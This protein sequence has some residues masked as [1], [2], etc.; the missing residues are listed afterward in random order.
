MLRAREKLLESRSSLAQLSELRRTAFRLNA[1]AW[2]SLLMRADKAVVDKAF[3]TNYDCDYSAMLLAHGGA[4]TSSAAMREVCPPDSRRLWSARA[5]AEAL[6]RAERRDPQAMRATG[7]NVRALI[8]E[9][10]QAVCALVAASAK[11]A[12]RASM[13]A[14]T[15]ANLQRLVSAVCA[16]SHAQTCLPFVLNLY[17]PNSCSQV[18]SAGSTSR[19]SLAA[20]RYKQE[21]P[22][23]TVT[24]TVT[25]ALTLPLILI[26]T[27]ILTLSLTLTLGS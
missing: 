26:P 27:L 4:T 24:L 23:L 22:A 25:V 9:R 18:S 20:S 19:T 17:P 21:P 13:S 6:K 11:Q 14:E 15:C 3:S 8:E 12:L 7:S 1:S 2:A 10:E 16:D 5:A